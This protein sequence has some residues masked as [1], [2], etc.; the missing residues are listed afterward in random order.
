M[1]ARISDSSTGPSLFIS[2]L[3]TR[4]YD[5]FHSG[6]FGVFILVGLPKLLLESM[7]Q[8]CLLKDQRQSLLK[9]GM[10]SPSPLSRKIDELR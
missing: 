6:V 3:G 10:K 8:C 9:P 2:Q 4:S 7:D 5:L 1:E